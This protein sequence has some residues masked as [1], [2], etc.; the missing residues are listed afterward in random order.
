[1]NHLV[2]MYA[3]NISHDVLSE[4][5]YIVYQTR[6]TQLSTKGKGIFL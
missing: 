4:I 6:T 1:M 5:K 3:G 2:I